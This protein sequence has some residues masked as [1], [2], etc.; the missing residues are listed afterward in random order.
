MSS[1]VNK[2]F[3]CLNV[4]FI[5]RLESTE[6]AF[7]R[8]QSKNNAEKTETHMFLSMSISTKGHFQPQR[9]HFALHTIA[10]AGQ[11]TREFH[12]AAV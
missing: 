3:A 1:E 6:N 5:N 9:C 12:S 4:H 7:N 11:I 10:W 2:T 8:N